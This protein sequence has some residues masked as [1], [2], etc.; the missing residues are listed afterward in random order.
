MWTE[1][2]VVVLGICVF[3]V[4]GYGSEHAGNRRHHPGALTHGLFHHFHLPVGFQ[5]PR[6]PSAVIILPVSEAITPHLST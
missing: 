4:G 5:A 3:R 1:I 6:A 2:S